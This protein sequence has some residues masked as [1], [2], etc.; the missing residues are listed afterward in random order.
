M[1]DRKYTFVANPYTAPLEKDF[2]ID[3]N[4]ARASMG[5]FLWCGNSKAFCEHLFALQRQQPKK[6]KQN[7]HVVPSWKNYST[8]MATFTLSTSFDVW[9]SQAKRTM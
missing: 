6:Q 7:V 8:S 1:D 2:K 5:H 4:G 3:A 9:A